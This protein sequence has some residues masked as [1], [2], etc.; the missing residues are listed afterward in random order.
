M[1]VEQIQQGPGFIKHVF[2]FDNETKSTLINVLQYLV[3]A[4]VPIV[5]LG[6]LVD[7]FIPE[8]MNRKTTLKF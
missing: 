8:L 7:S 3:I 5:L 2:N 6:G 4:I 1:E